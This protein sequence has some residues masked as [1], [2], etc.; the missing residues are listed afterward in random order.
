MRF[1]ILSFLLVSCANPRFYNEVKKSSASDFNSKHYS[2]SNKRNV[3][4][5]LEKQLKSSK[6]IIFVYSGKNNGASISTNYQALIKDQSNEII[7]KVIND[8]IS[9]I[10][11]N[12][13]SKNIN[14]LIYILNKYEKGEL[15]YLKSLFKKYQFDSGILNSYFVYEINLEDKIFNEEII[16]SF[17]LEEVMGNVPK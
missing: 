10:D 8:S 1:I 2:W 4:R 15:E 6:H 17:I 9:T 5:L 14:D 13:K 3:L 7:Y 16:E 12:D 11:Q